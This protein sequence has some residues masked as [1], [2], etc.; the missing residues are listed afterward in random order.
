MSISPNFGSLVLFLPSCE[1]SNE[2]STVEP[3]I[4]S[5]GDRKVINY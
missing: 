2:F 1:F 3:L 4:I 5:M